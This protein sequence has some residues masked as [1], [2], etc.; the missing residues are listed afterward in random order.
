[1]LDIFRGEWSSR[2]PPPHEALSAGPI[3]LFQ[4]ARIH[5]MV[6]QLGGIGGY[7]V[8]ELGP[9]EAGHSYML[10]RAGAVSVLAVEANQRAF[11]KCL[12]AKEILGLPTVDFVL[13]DFRE[14]LAGTREHWDLCVA[15]GVLYHMRE[16]VQLLAQ[17]AAHTDKLFLWTHYYEPSIIA[18]NPNLK[19]RFGA[20]IVKET[21]GFSYTLQRFNYLEALNGKGF[22]GGSA[23]YSHWLTR[24]AILNGLRHFGFQNLSIGHEAP[25]HPHGPSFA[26]LATR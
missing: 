12:I 15:S 16:P 24:D 6:Q 21:N 25:D 2:F 4:D 18:A 20:R 13:G 5:W 17:I 11:L 3:P 1:M 23:Q 8:L 9:L 26:V 14:F 10:D 22:C 7:R 19:H